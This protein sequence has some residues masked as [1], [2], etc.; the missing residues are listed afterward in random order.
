MASG[1][2]RGSM[3]LGMKLIRFLI[4]LLNL[5]FIMV[6]LIL[7]AIGVF[8]VR[9]P[10]MQ[11]L[12]P[13]LNP[14]IAAQ[15]SQGLSNI[16]I[17][18]IGLIAVGGVLLL[19]GFLGCC[20]AIKGFR[21]LHLLYAAVVS[22]VILAEIAIV[23]IFFLYQN[24]FRTQLVA[25]L[26]DSIAVNYVGIPLNNKTVANSASLS[27][28]FAQFNLQ[29]CGA[30]NKNDF[31]RAGNWTRQN[32]YDTSK[33]LVVPF[34]CCPLNATKS[35]TQLPTNYSSATQCATTGETAYVQGCYDRLVDILSA[36]K[37]G[38]IIGGVVVLVIEVLALV[39]AVLLYRRKEDEVYD[40]L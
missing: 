28:D 18:A 1:R 7:L 34:T 8:V 27:W 21:F 26:Q 23:V 4:V 13:L 5:A 35:W 24:G 10:K 14:D 30:V 38:V 3:S 22:L 17:F 36:Y 25:K 16:E 19:I 33:Q 20:G 9:D 11:Q 15:Y 29:C 31:I 40:T 37:T 32:P 12:R 6:G 39:F 2:G